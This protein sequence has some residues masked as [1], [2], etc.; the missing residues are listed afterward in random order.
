M[1]GGPVPFLLILLLQS[2]IKTQT[3]G[4]SK[5]QG[6]VRLIGI[7]GSPCDERK[8]KKSSSS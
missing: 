7:L 8:M 6:V 2:I 1:L 4:E 5:F 3:D